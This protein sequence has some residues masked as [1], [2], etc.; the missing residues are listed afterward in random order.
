[1]TDNRQSR[2]SISRNIPLKW[3][4]VAP[5][6]LQIIFAVG[7]VGYLSYRSGQEAIHK[8]AGRLQNEINTRVDEKT[9][10]YLQ[11]ID[12]INKNNISALRRGN[13][14]FDDFSSQER[15]AWEQMQLSSLFPMTIVGFGTPSGGHRAVERLKDGTF[16]I[17]AVQ[18]G[19]GSYMSFTT[20]PDGSPDK[21]M[22]TEINFD[23]RQRPWYQVAVKA[24][25]A[26]W[27]HVYQHIYTG[28]LLMAL[29]EPVY[30][31]KDGKLLGVTYGIR[32]L[33]EISRFLQTIDIRS[34]AIFIMERD[35]TLVANSVS[36]KPYQLSQ[37]SKAQQLLKA[38]D[39]PSLPISTAAKYL[40]DRLGGL[41][42]IKQAKQFDFAIN[43]DRQF[44]QA[45]QIS[46]RNGLDWIIVVAIP[47]SELMAEIQANKIWT[48]LLCVLT[49][50]VATGISLFTTRWI[51]RPILRLSLASKAIARR[52]WQEA[53]LEDSK[54]AEVKIL[55]ESFRQMEI[56][57][58][59]ADTLFA[60]YEQDLKRQ[61]TE[62]AAALIEAQ[63]I[64]RIG[65][66]EFDVATGESI[67]SDQQ[68]RILGYD[69][70]E[71]LP[72]YANFFDLLPL[73]DRPQLQAV[74]EE[75]IAHGTPYEVEHGIFRPDGSICHI[76]SRG[77]AI[78]DEL[79]KVIKLVGTITDISDR[80]QIETALINSEEQFRHAFEDASIGMAIVALDGHWIRVNNA[81]CQIVGYSPE[82]LSEL[83]FQDITHPD[84]LEVD[85]DYVHQL[86]AG[87][88]STYQMEKRCFH[89]QGHIVWILL[90]GSIVHDK[91]GNSLHFIA[92]IQDITTRKEAQKTLELQS[93]IMNNMAGGVCLIETSEMIIVYTNPKFN[94]MFGYADGELVGQHVGILNYFDTLVTP[95]VTVL[96]IATQIDRYGEA[97][98]EVHNRKKDGTLFWCRVHTSRFEHP[99]YGTVY[100]AVQQD[101]TELKLSE[102]A[103]QVT[104]NR[105]NFLLNYSPVVIFSSKPDGDYGATFVS[106]NI[107]EVMGYEPTEFLEESGFWFN[108]L[109]RDDIEQVLSGLESLFINDFY[110]HEYRLLHADGTY[111]WILNQLRLIRDQSG[112]PVE[113]LGYLID[114]SDR[115]QAELALAHKENQFQELSTASPSIIYTMVEDKNGKNHFE[116]ISL[117]AEKVH[118][119]SIVE[120]YQDAA[121]ILNQM[122]PDDLQG[123]VD[124][125]E[126][127]LENFQP[128]FHEWRI[129]TPSGKTKWLRANSRPS[130]RENGDIVL[131]GVASDVSDRKQ[132]ELDLQLSES[133]LNDILNSAT[134][135]ITRTLIKRDG[136]WEITYVSNACEAVSGYSVKELIE[137]QALWVS[138][139]YPEDWQSLGDRIYADIFNEIDGTYIYRFR[140]KD[141]SL[142]WMSQTNHSRWD[143]FLNA[144]VV[145]ILTSDISDRKQVEIALQFS[146]SRFKEMAASSPG[147][148]YTMITRSDGSIQFEYMS[149]VFEEIHEIK[150]EQILNDSSLY[151]NQIHPQ[152]RA[153][154]FKASIYSRTNLQPFSHEWR[155]ITPSGKLKWLQANSRPSQR[156]NGDTAWHGVILD[157][158]SRKQAEVLLQ[159]SE[160]TLIE[161]QRVAHIGNWEF[162]I[163]TN[164]IT[165]S[166]E[167]FHM[168]GCDPNQPEPIFSDYLQMIHADDRIMLQQRIE[169]AITDGIPYTIDYRA[170]QPD[171]SIRYHEGRAEVGRDDRGQV[172]R[173][174]G[175]SLDITDR[176]LVEIELAITKEKAEAAT[177]AKS[178]FLANMSH[179][180]RTP[181]NGV[182]GMAQLLET[183]DLSEE[184]AD[185]VSTII[186]SGD[187]LLTII[188][189]I[190]DFSKI[191][192]RMLVIEAK[193][194]VIEEVV[195]AVCQLLYSQAIAKQ[196]ELKYTI[197]SDVPVTA[198]G[199][200]NRLRQV[201]LNLIG[202]AIKF[203]QQG[204][205]TVS[206][207]GR[208]KT[209]SPTGNTY[210]LKFAI[211][212]TGIGIKGDRLDRLFQPFTQA[213]S[214]TSRQFGGTGLGL[215]ISKRLVE[216]MGGTIWVESCGQ[217]GGNPLSDW[218]SEL[219]PQDSQGSIFY[220]TIAVSVSV[221]I[222]QPQDSLGNKIAQ[223]LIDE[224]M[225]EKFP[226]HILLVEDNVVNQMFASILLKKLGYKI[227]VANNGLE[228]LQLVQ[229][230]SYDLI[231]MDVQM[232]EMDG[233]TTTRLIRQSF[234]NAISKV[235]IVAM[236]GN[237]MPEDRQACF[238]AGMDD[239]ISKPINMQEIIRL[240][241]TK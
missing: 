216:L 97:E 172:V 135:V 123:Y 224:R 92:Q 127:S 85:L 206:I 211:A 27:T 196:I 110:S 200:R 39:S 65:S 131:H 38:I 179:E 167:L 48:V 237:A 11:T 44:V 227:D 101:V 25:K 213:D 218:R 59:S 116:Y 226:L 220:F 160:S 183:T 13:W 147:A 209:F 152:D 1:M 155:I 75:A 156:E 115:K 98:Y 93:I 64:A 188:N 2:R 129:I 20:N 6:L 102:Q 142:R 88:I 202:N 86:L 205:V 153:D 51:T 199:D 171:G 8:L 50:I 175:T 82:E 159:K 47:E 81:L 139:I 104:T 203:T 24:K 215:A 229:E 107:R 178:E 186:Q 43:G 76:V 53:L 70:N 60:N 83:T 80:K 221:A 204:R 222:G 232:P 42:N 143:P 210:E 19:G 113:I 132:L 233:L 231:L 235:R 89:K 207:S 26:A 100:V 121:L 136:T 73:E 35:G 61:F 192:S 239:Y 125:V 10:T 112:S 212:D 71:S 77:E 195:S 87:T 140:H 52:E 126:L 138:S 130:R 54:I 122:H 163:Q 141:G 36:Q 28:E 170:I 181:M 223:A 151:L 21:G 37:N 18:N 168:F 15:Q 134:A 158:T 119:V 62:K 99:E 146:E 67:W 78:R 150:T 197:A 55:T 184:Q 161:A 225:A 114:I 219:N 14:S 166:K 32:T 95:E 169:A 128:F 12:Q 162:D 16:V 176:K 34:G 234:N 72:L 94:A 240:I 66:W 174:F 190:L 149:A 145:T 185:F 193:S 164:K 79:G 29:A 230:R 30:E 191:E 177:K 189:D 187:A 111:R 45:A 68:F 58:Q 96:D 108:H 63:R 23:S 106:E 157:V 182:L 4:I 137:D 133:K 201:L 40:R 109:H 118:E 74:V 194:F 180:I 173:L 165:W 31:L 17:R 144:Y 103:L 214:S 120:I 91:Q 154:Y 124:A 90:N 57:L 217:I 56:D 208:F 41:E 9:T 236:T 148:I 105:L 198:I 49:L 22:Q 84:D 238:E 117:I 7:L 228:A 5:F 241:K 69:P 3:L 33:E 46:D